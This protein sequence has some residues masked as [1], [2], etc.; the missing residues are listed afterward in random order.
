MKTRYSYCIM[1]LLALA[2]GRSRAQAP[3]CEKNMLTT[4]NASSY[5][6]I[7]NPKNIS[8]TGAFTIEFWAQSS[9]F[10]AHSGLVE[11]VNKGDTG[12]F[13]IGFTSGDFIIASLHL[14]NGIINIAT[15]NIANIQN[16]NHYAVTFTPTDSIRIFINGILKASQKTSASKLIA[17]TD[18]ILIAH[19]N[20]SGV[21]FTGNIDELRIWGNAR[22]PA[23]ILASMKTA[24]T[25]K[26]TG[27]K[28]Y[29]SFDDDPSTPNVH[30]FTGSNN[31]GKMISSSALISSTSPVTG[32]TASY[33]LA[34]KELS[35]IFPDLICDTVAD[36][37]VHVF[38]RGSEEVQIDPV[39]FQLGTIFSATTAGFPLPPDS[40]HLGTVRIHAAPLKPGLYHDTLIIPS[41]TVCGGILHIPVELRVQKISMAFQDSVFKLRLNP[42]HDLLPC[43]LPLKSQT[44]LKNTGTKTTT[45][46]SLQFSVQAGIVIDS[47]QTPFTIDS[48]KSREIKFTVLPGASGPISTILTA[49]TKVNECSRT[50]SITFQG[51]RIRP[52]FSIPNT[53]TFPAIHL[54]ATSI[55]IDTTITFKNT[56]TSDL[57]MNPP[58]SLLGGPGYK[59]LSPP[60]GLASLKP[61][62]TLGIKIRFTTTECGTFE[63]ALHFQDLINCGIDTLIPISITV[64]GPD[65]STASGICDFGVSCN[66]HDTTIMLFNKSGRTV[67]LGKPVFAR[68]SIFYLVN[69][70]FPKSLE[71]DDSF[72]VTLRFSPSE[73]G[74]YTLNAHFPLSPCGDAYIHLQGLLGIGQIALSDSS[75]DFGNGCD[76]SAETKKITVTNQCGRQIVVTNTKLEGSQN[77]SVISPSVPFTMANNESK[78]IVVQ[79]APQQLSVEQARINLYDSGCF[80][81][82]FEVRGVR[83]RGNVAWSHP[84]IVEFGTVCP[85]QIDTAGSL[86]INSGYG[87]DTI[88]SYRIIEKGTPVFSVA[89]INGTV[90]GH[91]STKQFSVIFS[92]KD[93][94]EFVGVLEA[95]LAPCK[96][97]IWLPLHGIGGPPPRLSLSDSLLN[98]GTIKFG[99]TDSLCTILVNPSCIPLIISSDSLHYAN[100]LFTL[101]QSSL[102]KLPDSVASGDP[103]TL[104]FVFAPLAMGSF[105]SIDT[106]R[107]GDHQ[108]IITLRGSAG[109]SDVKFNPKVFDFGD[110]LRGNSD[111]L[112]LGIENNGTFPA[113]LVVVNSVA[114]DFS[115]TPNNQTIGGNSFDTDIIVFKPSQLGLQT[116]MIV[117]SWENHLETIYLRGRGILPGLQ[118]PSS[119]LDFA[120]VRV[121]HDSMISINVANNL[122]SDNIIID[123]VSISGKFSVSPSGPEVINPQKTLAYTITYFP[124]AELIDTGAF[125]IHA[126]NSGDAILPL[127]GE[128][129]EAHLIV[130]STGI[131]FGTVGLGRVKKRDLTISNTGGYPLTITNIQHTL[132]A[133]GTLTGGTF[134]VQPG[135]SVAYTVSFSPLRAITYLDTLRIDA[136]APEKYAL[137]SLT[138]KGAFEP[139][140]I[141]QVSYGIP[142][143]QAKV[144]DILDIPVSISGNDLSLFDLDSFRV[145]LSYDPNVI[146]FHDTVNTFGTLSSGFLVTFER[147]NHD[148]VIRITGSGRS[149]IPYPE[150]LFILQAEALLGPFDS[151]RIFVQSS[152]PKNT[153]DPLS[154]SGLFTVTDCGNYRG[155]I[156]AKGNYSVSQVKPN[157]VSSSAHIEYELGL[158]GRVHL[159]LYDA[160][161]RHIRTIIDDDQTKGKHAAAFSTDG[162]PSGEY[163][164][165]LKSL[166]Y[167]N[168]GSVIILN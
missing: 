147:L 124:N 25:G 90:I 127:R 70:T 165:V 42:K 80:V 18:S 99:T 153:S 44:L 46:T 101:S 19:S 146:F 35:V 141:P 39:A 4:P 163:I 76:L 72:P 128:G 132:S 108:R 126:R 154:S 111:T 95:V 81:T 53:I 120:K 57:T 134:I 6:V 7:A 14:N 159:D 109:L 2:S 113:S 93:T 103:L 85:G 77:F 118:F 67:V 129:V 155:G 96:D 140:G 78:E 152:D 15:S 69:G 36:T 45:I 136:D 83:E 107:I 102:A 142:D 79:F 143:E 34:S 5:A 29:Y 100:S 50:A 110:V 54:P 97:T 23:Q 21:T 105:E 8:L 73:P 20:L 12:A 138:G 28:A 55:N 144:G 51:K 33:M 63:T 148:S 9:S 112:K 65:V 82:R 43:E 26:E 91:G 161:G 119:L 164:Y 150:R 104:C 60:S 27:L 75:L 64:F 139:F 11:Q 92:S 122:D 121:G 52:Q 71:P 17:S 84:G 30:D 145:D 116:S 10:A 88:F 66:A 61:D 166:E 151:T 41:T 32:T 62:S 162:I 24:L 86:L 59:L 38:N 106:L 117:F 115:I 167:E 49:I 47:P 16:W 131:N 1:V 158:S 48:G 87:D 31:E 133:F 160:L 74:R 137:V 89:N 114:Q 22:T 13:S 40:A 123:S 157:P 3:S 37:I 68:D 125:V 56:G 58:L 168:R 98:F 94:G 130:D 135:S 156:I 149:I